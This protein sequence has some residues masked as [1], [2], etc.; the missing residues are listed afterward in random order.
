MHPEQIHTGPGFLGVAADAGRAAPV[1]AHIMLRLARRDMDAVERDL[2]RLAG[3]TAL[4]QVT[5]D[6][7]LVVVVEAPHAKALDALVAEITRMR[8]VTG[9]MTSRLLPAGRQAGARS[10]AA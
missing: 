3:L 5:G 7:D 4:H 8:G 9:A 1:L 10:F 2:A 6:Y